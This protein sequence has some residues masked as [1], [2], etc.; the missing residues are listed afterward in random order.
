MDLLP[1]HTYSYIITEK[2]GSEILKLLLTWVISQSQSSGIKLLI[3]YPWKAFCYNAPEY[4]HWGPSTTLSHY[5]SLATTDENTVALQRSRTERGVSVCFLPAEL[6]E[7]LLLRVPMQPPRCSPAIYRE[8]FPQWF[9]HWGV[10]ERKHWAIPKLA[11]SRN[12]SFLIVCS[13]CRIR[14]YCNIYFRLDIRKKFFTMRVVK[15]WNGLPREV[16]EAPSLETFKTRLDRALSN[17]I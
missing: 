16:V 2:Q 14:V 4:L 12:K 8:D 11:K 6:K 13:C 15:H 9:S 1:K 3:T 10:T 17:L 5:Q 7:E